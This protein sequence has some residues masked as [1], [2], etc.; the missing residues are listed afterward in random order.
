M[1]KNK[2]A[3][4]MVRLR[5]KKLSP[6]RRKEIAS[7]ASKAR[8]DKEKIKLCTISEKDACVSV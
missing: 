8:W 6:K 7:I 3:Q 1:K 5:N 2:H 4:E